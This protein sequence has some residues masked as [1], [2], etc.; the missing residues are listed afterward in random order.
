MAIYQFQNQPQPILFIRKIMN[1]AKELLN[2]LLLLSLVFRNCVSLDIITPNQPSKD[3]QILVSNKKTFALGFFN[4]GNSYRRYV[5]IWYYHFT[6]QTVVWVANRDN[7]LND[8]S[9]VLHTRNQIV[10]IWSTNAS[11]P[12]SSTNNSMAKLLDI[13]NLILVQ[14][15]NQR[16][17]W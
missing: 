13:R 10:P 9:G 2:T 4:L 1:P 7:P 3:G 8:T 6:E 12:V 14:Q 17:A 5:G 15:D 11:F 16:V